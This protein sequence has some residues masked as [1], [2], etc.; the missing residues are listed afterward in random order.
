MQPNWLK[1]LQQIPTIQ[2]AGFID[3]EKITAGNSNVSF[4]VNS[5]AGTWVVRFNQHQFGV[6]RLQEKLILDLIAPLNISPKVIDANPEAGY[7]ITAHSPKA[8]WQQLNIHDSD[9]ILELADSINRFHQIPYTY[10]PSRL[11]HRIDTYLKHIKNIPSELHQNIVQTVK[12]LQQLGFWEACNTLYHSDLNSSNILGNKSPLIIDWE[13]AGQGHPLLDW[14][15]ME[16]E[17]QLD[18]SAHY[19]VK[20][21]KQ[22]LKPGKLLIADLMKLWALND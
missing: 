20:I 9:S 7:L 10:L 4:K 1:Q 5:Q 17:H 2:Q 12:V 15:I 6:N 22:W 8:T 3:C 21:N 13:F 11:D 18:L 16:H 19:P 14:L